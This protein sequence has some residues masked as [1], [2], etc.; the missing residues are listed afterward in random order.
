[1]ENLNSLWR[2]TLLLALFL[3][4]CFP[5]PEQNSDV[6][7]TLIHQR[8]GND[9]KIPLI[10]KVHNNKLR[11]LIDFK[12]KLSDKQK[13]L[14]EESVKEAI[15]SWL[16]PLRLFVS[17][18]NPN[19]GH[20]ISKDDIVI[21]RKGWNPLKFGIFPPALLITFRDKRGRSE[22]LFKRG[23]G[24]PFPGYV[25]MK[26]SDY[27]TGDNYVAGYS[28]STLKHEIGHAMGLDDTYEEEV[29]GYP[30]KGAYKDTAGSQPLSVMSCHYKGASAYRAQLG[31]D[32]IAGIEAL[33][34]Y[35][36]LKE[37]DKCHPSYQYENDPPGCIPKQPLI[38]AV[39]DIYGDIH[40][41]LM[42]DPSV[43]VNEKGPCG[44]TALHEAIDLVNNAEKLY[45]VDILL[46]KNLRGKDLDITLTNNEG[47]TVLH[48]LVANE[49]SADY[50]GKI[51]DLLLDAGANVN[52]KDNQGKTAYNYATE[53]NDRLEQNLLG[54]GEQKFPNNFINKLSPTNAE[55]N[56]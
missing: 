40:R 3:A 9:Y 35:H 18:Y 41:L 22:Y 28:Y 2:V 55:E 37:Y 1:M 56:Q 25:N 5:D 11:I 49:Y 4:S 10:K 53:Y 27:A 31:K 51:L 19:K 26:L 54:A 36:F 50:S 13:T 48:L 52:A 16:E 44:N 23:R 6:E 42:D 20:I 45:A 7:Y 21:K 34:K 12:G 8:H 29:R 32:D 38:F 33:Y 14:L 15:D 43:D 39:R 47:Q 30:N 24:W 17:K 46:D